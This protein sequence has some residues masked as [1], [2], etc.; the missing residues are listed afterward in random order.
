V[1]WAPVNTGLTGL[2]NSFR[3]LLSVQNS[4]ARRT[5]AV[6]AAILSDGAIPTL[7]GVFRSD[8]LGA[9]WTALGAPVPTIFPGGQTLPHGAL[10]ADP[11]DSN[12][13]FVS[14]DFGGSGF[15]NTWR[16]DASLLPGS[17]WTS[18]DCNGANNTSP[19]ADSR[20]MVFDAAGN[21]LQA[22]DGGLFRLVDPNNRMGQR[23]WLSVNGDIRPTEFHSVAYDPLSGIVFG[24][25]QDNGTPMQSAPGEFTWLQL[26]AGDGG[27]PNVKRDGMVPKHAKPGG[28]GREYPS[29]GSAPRITSSTAV[30]S[31]TVS[32]NTETQSS[33]RQAGTTTRALTRPRVGFSPTILL[34]AAGTR[35]EPAV[36][37]PSAK[38]TR[39]AATA[40]AEP[41][42]D[43]P[44][45]KAGS[46]GFGGTP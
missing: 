25:T 16:G 9:T 17:P 2:S 22:N 15:G 21:L 32:A 7:E 29:P 41:E 45:M 23:E 28:A 20:A 12:V 30:A 35:P 42:L 11:T 1:T 5:N 40:T 3:I 34:N 24:G 18:L 44:G 46:N 27:T 8:N 19:H 37:V 33:E 39:P 31:G 13:V 43:P 4:R 10:V 38:A 26:L 36:S 14:G 6:Y